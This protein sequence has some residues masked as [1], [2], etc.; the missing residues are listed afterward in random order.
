ML[1]LLLYSLHTH[2]QAFNVLRY[3]T[4][5]SVMAGLTALAFSLAMGPWLIDRFRA[6]HVGQTIRDVVPQTHQKKAG[7]PTMGG[8]LILTA[9]LAATLSARRYHATLTSGLSSS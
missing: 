2:F 9:T 5:R 8:L 6:A 7:T 4:F 1:Y 3:E